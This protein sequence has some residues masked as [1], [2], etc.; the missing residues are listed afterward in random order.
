MHSRPGGGRVPSRF[1]NPRNRP[2]CT[3][4]AKTRPPEPT[5]ARPCCFC[6]RSLPSGAPLPWRAPP[7][8]RSCRRSGSNSSRC[9]PRCR[10]SASRIACS[11]S[12]SRRSTAGSRNWA[13]SPQPRLS[14]QP[15]AARLVPL[16]RTHRHCR[17]PRC[18]PR[19]DPSLAPSATDFDSGVTARCITPIRPLSRRNRSSIS[20]A[21]C[22]ASVTASMSARS[23][24]PNTRWSTP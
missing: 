10:N 15:R 19:V 14:R 24:T 16:R 3:R 7:A 13:R 8:T 12:T 18:P 5:V 9:R 20:R 22:S 21:R 23:S 11:A 6:L 1:S 2:P 17:T 4:L